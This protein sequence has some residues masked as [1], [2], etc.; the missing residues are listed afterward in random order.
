M[1]YSKVISNNLF[2]V[3]QKIQIMFK[4]SRSQKYLLISKNSTDKDYTIGVDP[5]LLQR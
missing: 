4:I 5:S 3:D 2:R 1:I